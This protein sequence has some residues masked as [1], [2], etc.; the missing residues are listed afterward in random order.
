MTLTDVKS[1]YTPT[2]LSALRIVAALIMLEHG[3]QKIINFPPS[4]N[5]GMFTT[6]GLIAGIIEICGSI[7]LLLGLFTSP[8]AFIF[9]GEMAVAY[10]LRHAPRGLYPVNNGGELAILLCFVFLYLS[11]AGPGALKL[12]FGKST[13][14]L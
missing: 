4:P 1:R 10:F 8:I 7:P 2:T 11:F 9:S 6:L 5:P 13:P 12:P 14:N 3:L